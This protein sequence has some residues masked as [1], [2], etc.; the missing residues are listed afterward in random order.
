MGRSILG[1][2]GC[3]GVCGGAC[4]TPAGEARVVFCNRALLTALTLQILLGMLGLGALYL[5][6]YSLDLN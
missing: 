2:G 1:V 4:K 5:P 6:A 3:E